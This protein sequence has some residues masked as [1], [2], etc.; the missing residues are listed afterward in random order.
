[1]IPDGDSEEHHQCVEDQRSG[2]PSEEAG[3]HLNEEIDREAQCHSRPAHLPSFDADV[4]VQEED[5]QQRK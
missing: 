4:A 3:Q 5:R 2:S 1:M